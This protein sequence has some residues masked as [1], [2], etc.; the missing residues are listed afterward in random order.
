MYDEVEN[1]AK[2]QRRVEEPV[3]GLVEAAIDHESSHPPSYRGGGAHPTCDDILDS[4]T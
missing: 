1:R 3:A 4:L 2:I